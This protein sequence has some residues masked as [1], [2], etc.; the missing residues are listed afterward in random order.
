M[1][2]REKLMC[3]DGTSKMISECIRTIKKSKGVVVFGAGVGGEA[4]YN[5]LRKEKLEDKILAWTDNNCLKV[6]TYYMD[7]RLPVLNP[8]EASDR[9]GDGI[10]FVISSSAFDTIRRQLIEYGIDDKMIVLFNFAFMD[11]EY[12]DYQFIIDHIDEFERAYE[13]MC[14]EKSRRIFVCI[15]NYRITKDEFWLKNMQPYVDDEKGQY[16]DRELFCFTDSE[17]LLDI[18]AYTGDTFESF[19]S[20]YRNGWNHYY[21][22]EA[23]DIIFLKLKNNIDKYSHLK[24]KCTIYNLAAWDRSETLFFDNVAGSSRMSKEKEVKK[25]MINADRIE[26]I[27]KEEVTIIKMDIEGAEYQA[28]KGLETTIRTYG[29]ILAICAYHLRDDFFRLTNLVESIN[30][31]AYSFYL[32]QYRYTPSE[33]VLYAIP[34]KRRVQ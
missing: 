25:R 23:D 11:L 34:E 13:M 4:L 18:G 6:G 10:T 14:D 12:T 30:P 21:G 29:P 22:I 26:N 33:T 28:L 1:S 15:L 2:L 27:I 19:I 16:F 9:F 8:K 3:S 5:L 24:N 31:N 17:V 32:R 20:H 7:E